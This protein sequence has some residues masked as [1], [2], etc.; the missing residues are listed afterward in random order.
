MTTQIKS[1]IELAHEA[2]MV[3]FAPKKSVVKDWPI[4]FTGEVPHLERLCEAYAAQAIDQ[5]KQ[6][7]LKG[8]ELPEPDAWLPHDVYGASGTPIS[9]DDRQTG[10]LG[11]SQFGDYWGGD[12]PL[13]SE[14][15]FH[16]AIAA[17]AV[18]LKAEIERL[19]TVPMKYRRMAFNAELQSQVTQLE[20]ELAEAL[21]YKQDSNVREEVVF[22]RSLNTTSMYGNRISH[23]VRWLDSLDAA[24]AQEKVNASEGEAR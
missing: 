2:G 22:L 15:K 21:A 3:S 13:F 14:K 9:A 11:A 4:V 18:P 10:E 16:Q 17:A 5:Y 23:L 20:Q 24:R 19:K 12:D 1:V 6:E 7:L 8:V